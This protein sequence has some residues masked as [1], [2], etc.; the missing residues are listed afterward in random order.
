MHPKSMLLV[1]PAT[2][3]CKACHACTEDL[4][5]LLGKEVAE[6]VVEAVEVVEGGVDQGAAEV[7]AEDNLIPSSHFFSFTTILP[8]ETRCLPVDV[9]TLIYSFVTRFRALA[10]S[11]HQKFS[12]AFLNMLLLSASVYPTPT[13]LQ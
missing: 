8:V 5:G 3:Y 13:Q 2:N 7:E 1:T 4:N 9:M 10:L 11:F 6:D 12:T